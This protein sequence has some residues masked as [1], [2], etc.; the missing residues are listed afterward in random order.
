MDIMSDFLQHHFES[1][2][3]FAPIL[4]IT[5]HLLRPLLFLPIIIICISGGVLFGTFAGS[6][7]SMVGITLSSIIF[8]L[9]M[10]YIPKPFNFLNRLK[11]MINKNNTQLSTAQI[12]LL[13]LIPF[14]HFHALSIVLIETSSDFREYTKL[15][16]LTN[17]PLAIVYTTIGQWMIHLTPLYIG[18][19]I[20]LLLI[21]TYL[22][23]RKT[24]LINW[25][26]FFQMG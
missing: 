11:T 8:Y 17:M 13:R 7:Y 19:F 6:L 23:R 21:I 10:Q 26:D 20:F 16:L 24:A 3:I 2:G 5:F 15:S 9:I 25:H 4:F 22:I 18:C 14:I 12:A 1:V